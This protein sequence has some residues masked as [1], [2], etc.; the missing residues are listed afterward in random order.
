MRHFDEVELFVIRLVLLLGLVLQLG[1][2]L[3]GQI[4]HTFR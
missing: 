4:H 1:E 2:F 3:W